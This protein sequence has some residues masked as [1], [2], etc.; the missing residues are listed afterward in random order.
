M[1]LGSVRRRSCIRRCISN[2]E[3]GPLPAVG[4]ILRRRQS[5][6]GLRGRAPFLLRPSAHLCADC[7][8]LQ[9]RSRLKSG[10]RAPRLPMP[11]TLHRLGYTRS[12]TTASASWLGRRAEAFGCSRATAATSFVA[13]TARAR[14]RISFLSLSAAYTT[15]EHQTSPAVLPRDLWGIGCRIVALL[16]ARCPSPLKIA[17]HPAKEQ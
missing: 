8:M 15:S 17:P 3:K 10:F 12:S 6:V 16:L 14:V 9:I 11:A 7:L 4:Y 13:P 2:P 1:I 5:V